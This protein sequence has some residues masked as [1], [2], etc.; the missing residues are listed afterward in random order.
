MV[1]IPASAR[2][3]AGQS[4]ASRSQRAGAIMA[5]LRQDY[6]EADCALT[7]VNVWQL[8]VATILSAQ[9]TDERVNKVTPG[10]FR[11]FPSI[12]A[13]AETEQSAIEEEIHST[14]FF[15][16]KAKSIQGAARAVLADHDGKVPEDM[17]ALTALPGVGRK[18]AHV[19]RGTFFGLPAITVDTHVGRLSRRLGLT[20]QTDPVKVERD[21]EKLLPQEDRTFTSHALIWHGRRVCFARK[22]A[23]S[24]CGMSTFCPSAESY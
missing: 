11:R 9:C 3:A 13:F 22:P 17:D 14:G 23:C 15:R 7:F 20:R 19:V 16:N 5:S 12:E 10:L 8:L 21:L 24:S 4:L 6:S 18:T 2:R 1:T